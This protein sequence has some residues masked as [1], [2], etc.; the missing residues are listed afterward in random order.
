M[1]PNSYTQRW[2]ASRVG[3][4]SRTM[5]ARGLAVARPARRHLDHRQ[6]FRER[7]L[8]R[9]FHPAAQLVLRNAQRT[10]QVRDAAEL[11]DGAL[12]RFSRGLDVPDHQWTLPARKT[13]LVS[14]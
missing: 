10:S 2:I 12:D 5:S 1:L 9:L 7:H 4:T 13:V 8:V 3:F 6:E 11:V 14:T